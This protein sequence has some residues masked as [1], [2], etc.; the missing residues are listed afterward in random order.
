[1]G[2]LQSL[3]VEESRRIGRTCDKVVEPLMTS[4]ER[5]DNEPEVARSQVRTAH[6]SDSTR[7]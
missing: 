6:L 1:M 5:A 4:L 3:V 2:W 7:S